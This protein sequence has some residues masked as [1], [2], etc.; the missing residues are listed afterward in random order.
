ME[1]GDALRLAQPERRA[2]AAGVEWESCTRG[3]CV[4]VEC[5]AAC[6]RGRAAA[7]R[8][9]VEVVEVEEEEEEGEDA[10]SAARAQCM[11]A[12]DCLLDGWPSSPLI[13]RGASLQRRE[14]MDGC[15]QAWT[16]ALL[17]SCFCLFWFGQALASRCVSV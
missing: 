14:S 11:S 9:S 3:E 13:V 7:G 5:A 4:C 10:F 12:C 15:W 16:P 2:P 6:G 17:S 8:T 1:V